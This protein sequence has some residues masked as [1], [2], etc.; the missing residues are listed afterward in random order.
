MVRRTIGICLLSGLSATTLGQDRSPFDSLVNIWEERHRVSIR[1]DP[2]QTRGLAI[3]ELAG[4]LDD[5]LKNT[6]EGTGLS[7]VR[8]R[9]G[10]I[11][12]FRGAPI[13]PR[14]PKD[15]FAD[16]SKS[17]PPTQAISE[18]QEN[19]AFI[20][21]H[22]NRIQTIGNR[23]GQGP[24]ATITG[25]V[26]DAGS[27][28]PLASASITL[29]GSNGGVST[30]AF[31]FFTMTVPKGRHALKVSSVGMKEA[32]IQVN[33]LGNGR[34][35]IG[36]Q[37]EVRSLKAAVVVARKG[38]NVRGM[39]MGVEKLSIRAI[40][41]IP[42]V[43]GETDILRSLLTLPGV[44]SV[45]EG[46]VGYNVRGGAADQNLLLLNDMTV[47][48]PTH[49]FGFFSAVD[50]EVVRGLEL[51]KSAIPE[52]FGGRLSSIMDVT[53][54]DGNNKKIT[55]TAGIGPLTG[56]FTAEGPLGKNKKTTFI[57]GGRT[58][59]SN[60]FLKYL[61]DASLRKSRVNFGDI[62]LHLGHEI[63]PRDRL[64]ASAYL[65]HDD[66]RLNADSTYTYQNLNTRLKWRHD[67]TDKLYLVL[68]SGIDQYHYSVK[69]RNNPKD[70]FDLRFGIRQFNSKADFRYAPDNR[71]DLSFG[72]QHIAYQIQPGRRLPGNP[73]SLVTPKTVETEQAGESSA[74][75]GD[76][77]RASNKLSL[78]AGFR[79]THYRLNGP[80]KYYQYAPNQ[81]RSDRSVVDSVTYPANQR[82]QT[83]QGPE[84]RISSRYL[85]DSRTSLKL[86]FNTLRQYIHMVTNTTAISPTDIWKLSDPYIKPQQGQ[87]ISLGIYTQPG[88][89][90]TE[91][92][93]EAYYK[94]TRNYLDYK[95]G[96]ILILN[97][98]L[99][100][101]VLN[102]KGKAYGI[103]AL[104][105]KPQGKLNGWLSY[106][107]LRTF[108]KVDDPIAGEVINGGNHYPAN[109]DKPHIASLVANYRFN[110]RVSLSLTS[111]Y[112][113]GRPVTYPLG[114]FTMGGSS[115]VLY[116]ERNAF[117]IPDFFR[118]DASLLIENSHNLR[119][120]VHTSWTLG[121]Y[122]ITG[123]N[124]PYSVYFVVND[125][126]IRGYQLSVFASSIPFAT[127]NLKF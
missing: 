34:I 23:G 84:I 127:L 49:L 27:G 81:P 8:D 100:R 7:F 123:R 24:N 70:A 98:T 45:G 2:L 87:Q 85:I 17:R 21:A 122:N 42:A 105:R 44:T 104:I 67:F 30:D 18:R 106:T 62:I 58:T 77:Y 36:M 11:F 9:S 92:S 32:D 64:Y 51:Y 14:L 29:E 75:I 93:L 86:S 96:A 89:K 52:K 50:P 111:T 56:K 80:G 28:E 48:N 10:R 25:Y 125:R 91:L 12:I 26:R 74:Y 124:N 4:S 72:L 60:W 66:F 33:I 107:W 90:G 43:M 40:R 88:D 22:A 1:Y 37:E 6:L 54:R 35:D 121:I 76:Q 13:D 99:E 71:H 55:G 63:S 115:R 94:T 78:Q 46:T 38:S 118:T 126:Q 31:G 69:G 109:F 103:E 117:R 79:Y 101:D 116:S 65:S 110:Q 82:I 73:Q 59:Y 19:E 57:T 5:I 102:T 15:F 112:S 68:S 113:T 97:E 61:S 95:S 16:T 47:F 119:K 41:Q 53:T 3:P 114:V 39:Q 20:A 120:K 108:L 83:Y